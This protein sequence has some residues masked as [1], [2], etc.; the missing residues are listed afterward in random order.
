LAQEKLLGYPLRCMIAP[1]RHEKMKDGGLMYKNNA[2]Q[3]TSGLVNMFFFECKTE[4]TGGG[5][6]QVESSLTHKLDSTRFQPLKPI[7]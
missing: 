7:T 5:G 4:Y 6:V 1:E 3:Y 2:S